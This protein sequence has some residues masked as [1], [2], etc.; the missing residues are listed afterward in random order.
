YVAVAEVRHIPPI[1]DGSEG[2]VLVDYQSLVAGQIQGQG[3][4][5]VTSVAQL[6]HVWLSSSDNAAAVNHIRAV[7]NTPA[8]TLA[9]LMDRRA[10]SGD[11]AADPLVNGLLST[12]SIGVA[13]TL[14]L[15]FLANLLLP[16]LSVRLRQTNFAVL[17]ALGTAPDQVTGIL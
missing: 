17:R 6:N 13:A 14:L 3:M 1:D 4:T 15:A 2:A 11:S 12:I 10:L 7:L 8:F 16:L 9:Q 5:Q